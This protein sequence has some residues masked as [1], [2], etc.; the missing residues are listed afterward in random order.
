MYGRESVLYHWT[1]S[2]QPRLDQCFA[3]DDTTL[4]VG[5]IDENI[6]GRR[7]KGPIR[8][9]D[10]AKRSILCI[11]PMSVPAPFSRCLQTETRLLSRL[12]SKQ[13]QNRGSV[14]PIR[15]WFSPS[16]GY[17]SPLHTAQAAPKSTNR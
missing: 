6:C 1:T 8:C 11:V 12:E 2:G 15:R 7:T 13:R 17:E 5:L 10:N 4:P 3:K 9:A 16:T 14:V